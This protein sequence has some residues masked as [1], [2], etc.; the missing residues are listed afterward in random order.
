MSEEGTN[1]GRTKI[2]TGTKTKRRERSERADPLEI[3]G[4]SR[5]ITR[6]GLVQRHCFCF[7]QAAMISEKRQEKYMPLNM[8]SQRTATDLITVSPRE[9]SEQRKTAVDIQTEQ[10]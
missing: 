6:E 7:V 5:Q 8:S 1:N 3:G 2:R 9:R 4:R 10:P